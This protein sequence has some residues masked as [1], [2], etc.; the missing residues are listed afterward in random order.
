MKKILPL[1]VL[2]SLFFEIPICYSSPGDF[3]PSFGN[4][5]T[6]ELKLN[7]EE[8][9]VGA[10]TVQQDNKILVVAKY[11]NQSIVLRYEED[12]SIDTTFG[13]NGVVYLP[14]F[15]NKVVGILANSNNYI[16]VLMITQNSSGDDLLNLIGLTPN[17]SFNSGYGANGYKQYDW[18]NFPTW[19]GSWVS[20]KGV[21]LSGNSILLYG[22]SQLYDY[23]N[24]DLGIILKF[25][26]TTGNFISYKVNMIYNTQFI[27]ESVNSLSLLP[28]GKIAVAMKIL[29]NL[30]PAQNQFTLMRLTFAFLPDPTINSSLGNGIILNN[31]NSNEASQTQKILAQS[32]N[33][34]IVAGYLGSTN[35]L[36]RFDVN[37]SIDSTFGFNGKV[38]F[39]QLYLSYSGLINQQNNKI[40]VF[41][42]DTSTL[43]HSIQRLNSNGFLDTTFG[44]NG[45]ISGF[46]D[47][48][49]SIKKTFIDQNQKLIVWSSYSNGISQIQ[50]FELL[51]NPQT[52][53]MSACYKDFGVG[54]WGTTI[55]DSLL[56]ENLDGPTL[57]IS[58]ITLPPSFS[59]AP[60]SLLPP[61]SVNSGDSAF[62]TVTCSLNTIGTIEGTAEIFSNTN[63]S[64]YK[65]DLTVL[66][67]K[68][69]IQTNSN[70]IDFGF[71]DILPSQTISVT[72]KL[73]VTNNGNYDLV[74]S[75]LNV[76][77]FDASNFFVSNSLPVTIS[78]QESK[79]LDINFFTIID[80]S[81][82]AELQISSNDPI[83]PT[84]AI[85]LGADVLLVTDSKEVKN[86][87]PKDFILLPNYPNPFNPSTK[88]TFGIPEKSSVRLEIFNVLGQKVRTL[89]EAELSPSFYTFEWKGTDEFGSS[90]SSGVYFYRLSTNE[91]VFN[92]KM[93]F[94]K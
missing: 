68:P 52:P 28:N 88:I 93:L 60:N 36:T 83:S 92:R 53:L 27:S 20:P 7:G 85:S 84:V 2:L 32:D 38:D 37:G 23:Y 40:L 82:S 59:F 86:S 14:I 16:C 9:N 71:I 42:K 30:T 10:V 51:S 1:I 69:E 43:N 67:A 18:W 22:S 41:G 17:G 65:L 44:D 75:D 89:V 48:N 49:K 81:F 62:I 6:L 47:S 3:D 21:E 39:P 24:N 31:L 73:S 4:C 5:G 74:I 29:G 33:K 25:S 46:I 87:I 91:Q 34:M 13:L 45:S 55:T 64:P 57:N 70:F 76:S 15:S 72:E 8:L 77:G 80:G 26:L 90:V 78:P 94:V 61:F 58:N 79:D 12:G 63:Y 56:I 50:K 11:Q 54:Y 19:V 35:L 66:S